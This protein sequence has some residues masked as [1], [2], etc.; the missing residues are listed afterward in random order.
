MLIQGRVSVLLADSSKFEKRAPV[1]VNHLDKL[2]F[3][4]CD[5]K[6][7]VALVQSIKNLEAELIIA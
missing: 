4:I 1:R 7:N 5:E 6:P 2:S 3:V